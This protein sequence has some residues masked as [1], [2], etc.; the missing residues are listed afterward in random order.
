[1][2]KAPAPAMSN[3]GLLIA[4]ALLA[5]AGTVLVRRRKHGS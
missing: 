2:Q 4:A 1:V 3:S 5:V